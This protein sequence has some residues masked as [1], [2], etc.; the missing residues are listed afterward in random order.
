MVDFEGDTQAGPPGALNVQTGTVTYRFTPPLAPGLHLSGASISASNP[1]SGKIGGGPAGT[2]S[3]IRGEA[4]D[5]SLSTWVDINYQD[6]ATTSL[7][8]AV[9]NPATGEIR[10]RVIVNNGAF[11]TNGISLAGTAQ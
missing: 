3:T 7:P 10:V 1:F 5:W 8:A 11:L 9:I 4:W 6:N 2:T